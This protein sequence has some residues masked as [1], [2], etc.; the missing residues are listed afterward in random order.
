MIRR[1]Q[2]S[3]K[4]LVLLIFSIMC[5]VLLAALVS[6]KAFN[7]STGLSLSD[8]AEAIKATNDYG[9]V[10][11]VNAMVGI[12]VV[13]LIME[14]RWDALRV[15]L[16]VGVALL[17]GYLMTAFFN[18]DAA[19]RFIRGQ[20]RVEIVSEAKPLTDINYGDRLEAEFNDPRA[21]APL[22]EAVYRF[23]GRAGDVVSIL[24]F[25][26]NER[27]GM[28]LR[29]TLQ[30]SDGALLTEGAD[31]TSE[32]MRTF[33]RYLEAETDAV[34]ENFT[35]PSDGFYT[36]IAQPEAATADVNAEFTVALLSDAPPPVDFAY[37]SDPVGATFN[38]AD[39][40]SPISAI[41]YR[42]A[43]RAGDR[44]DVLA[45]AFR[46][47]LDVD[48]Q[49][50]LI[51]PSG[52]EIGANNDASEDQV[53]KFAPRLKSTR[54]AIIEG[55]LLPEDGFY[56]VHVQ[57]E[58]LATSTR[59]EETLDATNKAYDAFLFGPLSRL[60][61]WVSWI[62]DALTLIMLGLAFVVVFRAE[63]FS[64]GADGQLYFGALVSAGI[65]LTFGDLPPAILVP[66]ALLSAATAGF[67]WG[68]LPGILKAYLGANE[69][70]STLMLNTI[71]M[72]FYEMVLTFQLKPSDAGYISSDWI[73]SN[74]LLSP[75]IDVSGDQITIAVF[76]LIAM[77]IGT[78]LLIQR[79]PIGYE[80]RM[81][82]S[83]IK[84]A[85]YGGVNTKRTIMLA[86]AI[87]G[88]IA[89]LSGAHLAM[90]VHRKLILNISLSLGFEGVVVALLARNNP[91]VAPFTGLLYAY[92]RTGAQVME[93]D[94]NVSAEVVRIIQAVVILLITAEALVTFFRRRRIRRRGTV[95]LD[96]GDGDHDR[97]GPLTP[98][99]EGAHG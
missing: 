6:F 4:E 42:F 76:L 53:A 1:L 44:V 98:A 83:N 90:G 5:G 23:A 26:A 71:A 47:N 34:I 12:S 14:L 3:S 99:E 39:A 35:L 15:V 36:I 86:M 33:R 64:L 78:W 13:L 2:P 29:V 67:L 65:G 49:V 94:A 58:P 52:E 31:A 22:T 54:D 30:D 79:T 55:I 9:A 87:G 60:N 51:A 50:K 19:D 11:F 46:A 57:P 77:V 24:A 8:M 62:R 43:G 21:D 10:L 40:P 63:Q 70:V 73:P 27:D 59:F 91:L 82:G 45:Y 96:V 89:G 81:I 92:L 41:D 93:R 75:I 84:F 18:L 38:D 68:L 95:E 72:R 37:N 28:D 7:L 80:I 85:D 66:I 25:V 97:K 20:F 69:L 16:T 74:G 61:R 48:V 56:T 17:F 88:A 32:Q